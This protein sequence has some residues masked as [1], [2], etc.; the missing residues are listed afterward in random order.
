MRVNNRQ[1]GIVGGFEY[2]PLSK[3]LGTIPTRPE[4]YADS[5]RPGF[6][7]FVTAFKGFFNSKKIHINDPSLPATFDL[8]LGK[9]HVVSFFK[10]GEFFFAEI[11]KL[12]PVNDPKETGLPYSAPVVQK[13]VLKINEANLIKGLK[14]FF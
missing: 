6:S 4:H 14:K 1:P 11:K 7:E 5:S 2:I 3:R 10:F 8:Y 13:I 9:D 12:R